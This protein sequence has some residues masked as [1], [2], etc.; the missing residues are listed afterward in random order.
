MRAAGDLFA[1]ASKR[2]IDSAKIAAALQMTDVGT[3]AKVQIA[4]TS[5]PASLI[6]GER[7]SVTVAVHNDSA[8][9]LKSWPPNPVH[10]SYHWIDSKT[11]ATLVHDG[12]RSLLTP[13]SSAG[14]RAEYTLYVNAPNSH[15]RYILRATLVQEGLR[16]FDATGIFADAE[17]NVRPAA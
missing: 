12:Q 7:S 13:K 16:W 10:L 5:V 17:V 15:G 11:G 14:T 9:D 1:V 8:L 3:L 4:L 6:S 2:P